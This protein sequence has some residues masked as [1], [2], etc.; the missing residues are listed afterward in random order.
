MRPHGVFGG[1]GYTMVFRPPDD[2]D[3]EGLIEKLRSYEG[4]REWKYY[5]HDGPELRERLLAAGLEPDDEETVVVAEA[6]SIPPPP[7]DVDLREE[8]DVF[9]ELAKMVFGHDRGSIMPDEAVA[10]VAVVDGRPVSGGRVDLDPGVEFAGLF[11]G[12]TVPEYRGRGLYRATVARRAEIARAAG[13]RFF[14]VDALPTSRPILERNGFVRLT[15]TTPFVI[16][17][18]A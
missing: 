4:Y 1:D 15:A 9:L 14:Y 2:G 7:E 3:V 11:G 6:A 16:P 13:Y 18:G 10:V 8:P 12:V 5:E 17:K